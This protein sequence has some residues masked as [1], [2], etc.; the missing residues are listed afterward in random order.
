[1]TG[2]EEEGEEDVDASSV[3][4][5][6]GPWISICWGFMMFLSAG[7]QYSISA[8]NDQ[9]GTALH[10]GQS[11]TS[12]IGAIGNTGIYLSGHLGMF[13]DRYG[14]RW[15]SL[16]SGV[17]VACGYGFLRLGLF[18]ECSQPILMG[19]ALALVG[20]GSMLGVITALASNQAIFGAQRIGK[21]NGVLFAGFGVSGVIFASLFNLVDDVGSFFS[22]MTAVPSLI[23]VFGCV[24]LKPAP[25]IAHRAA[26]SEGA[27]A[28]LRTEEF[29]LIF[30]FVF[31]INGAVLMFVNNISYIGESLGTKAYTTSSITA[32]SIMNVGGR[33]IF[34]FLCDLLPRPHQKVALLILASLIGAIAQLLP[35]LVLDAP[36]L[37]WLALVVGLAEGSLVSVFPVVVRVVLGSARSATNF[38]LVVTANA[39]GLLVLFGPVF[40]H[41]YKKTAGNTEYTSAFL[42]SSGFC[43][44]AMI[45]VIRL[46]LLEKKR[47][48]A[49]TAACPQEEMPQEASLQSAPKEIPQQ[50]EVDSHR[51]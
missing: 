32:F 47:P 27:L 29:W 30:W 39:F 44:A 10:Y 25:A 18:L 7:S 46:T 48:M 36:A 6:M 14:T 51:S 43:L 1:M 16:L 12:L 21:V 19:L 26:R 23:M 40:A 34:G 50:E 3:L 31:I 42:V 5:V 15:A 37:P 11:D 2:E 38:S 49:G 33:L 35:A 20:Q 24:C 8:W 28:V 4:G 17:L 41:F 13:R 22:L 9:L 45:L